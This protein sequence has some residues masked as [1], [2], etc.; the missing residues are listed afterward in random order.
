MKKYNKLI[1]VSFL[2]LL[3]FIISTESFALSW[4]GIESD[5]FEVYFPEG[6]KN[7]AEQTLYFL[8]KHNSQVLKITGNNNE[9]KTKVVVEDIGLESNGFANNLKM[10]INIFT[11]DPLSS[12]ILGAAENWFRLVSIHEFTHIAQMSNYSDQARYP[13]KIFGNSFSP[14]VHV[15]LWVIEGITVYNESQISEYTGRLNDGYYHSIVASKASKD[16]LPGIGEAGYIHNHF[17]MGQ[18]YNYGGVFFEYLAKKYGEEKFNEFFKEYSSYYWA[19][20]I[21]DIFP[22]IG[23]DKAARKVYGKP[24]PQLFE[25][26][27]NYTSQRYKNWSQPGKKMTDSYSKITGLTS[28]KDKL[29]YFQHKSR[30]NRPYEYRRKYSLIE[31]NPRT[32]QKRVLIE[33]TAVPYGRIEIINDVIYYSV[34]NTSYGFSN[35]NKKGWGKVVSKNL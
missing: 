34:Y 29:Y 11:N 31:F 17:P 14:N 13:V 3:I 15:P 16:E 19:P 35:T 1:I 26:W 33:T 27:K 32:E 10:K 21:A 23:F 9:F 12:F 5:N 4:K 2:I 20:F 8:E 24:W 30:S 7:Q 18:W 25:E 28:A 6:Y 22:G